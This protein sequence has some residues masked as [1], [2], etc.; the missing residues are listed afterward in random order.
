MDTARIYCPRC[1]WRPSSTSLWQCARQ[2]GGCGWVWNTF[3]TRG[4]CP[5]CSGVWEITACHACKQFSIHNDWYHDD[6]PNDTDELRREE[7]LEGA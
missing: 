6:D 2:L 4:V 3:D 1:H 5:K 7:E